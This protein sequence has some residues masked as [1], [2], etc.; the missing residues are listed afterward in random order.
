MRNT[1]R[2]SVWS[3]LFCVSAAVF[4]GPDSA[5]DLYIENAEIR[6]PLP[7][8]TT[9]VVYLALVNDSLQD[10]IVSRVTVEA[11]AASELHQHLHRDGMM[12]M[13]RLDRIAVPA[14]KTLTFESGSYHIMAFRLDVDDKAMTADATYAVTLIMANGQEISAQ[15][16]PIV[17]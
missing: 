6:L 1:I 13:R 17:L 4:A 16:S 15:A 12:R 14:G 5:T 7:G 8:Q 3:F 10:R 2:A 9:A 11:A